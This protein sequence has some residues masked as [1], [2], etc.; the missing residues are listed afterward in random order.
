MGH[1]R[2][3]GGAYVLYSSPSELAKW[4]CGR[5]QRDDDTPARCCPNLAFLLAGER[6]FL[7][8]NCLLNVTIQ[9][10][11]IYYED[12]MRTESTYSKSLRSLQ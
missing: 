5:F 2:K 4:V 11:R 1:L 10:P 9:N 8:M 7:L 6:E 12:S 3:Q